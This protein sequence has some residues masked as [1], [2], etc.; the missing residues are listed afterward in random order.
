MRRDVFQAI[1]DPTRREII[2]LLAKEP[3]NLNA[4]ADR[5]A[6]SRPAISKHIKVL[7]ECGLI[8]IRRQGRERFCEARTEKLKEV[9]QWVGQYQALWDE[10]IDQLENYLATLQSN[11]ISNPMDQNNDFT[12]VSTYELNAPRELVFQAWTQAEHLAG[13]F[14][15]KGMTLKVIS[16][17]LRPG[18]M[19]HYEIRMP[20]GDMMYGRFIYG[21]IAPPERLEYITSFADANG[22]P[23]H[24]PLSPDWPLEIFSVVTFE[25]IDGKTKMTLSAKAHNASDTEKQAFET[26]AGSLKQGWAGTIQQL[27]SYLS[28]LPKG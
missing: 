25:E 20:S 15:P 9:A 5:F 21:V 7:T 18:G 10:K 22:N 16:L 3:M 4:V 24:H 1:A 2:Q 28:N 26:G 11:S 13:W 6:V 8:Q 14:G 12:F 17:D 27:H 23:V 19:F